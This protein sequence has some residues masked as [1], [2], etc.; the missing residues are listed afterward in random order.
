MFTNGKSKQRV[1]DLLPS[2]QADLLED[3]DLTYSLVFRQ[4]GLGRDIEVHQFSLKNALANYYSEDNLVLKP[5]DK[6]LIFLKSRC[7]Y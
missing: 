6:I 3:A 5:L 2:I 4:S 7:H 1:S